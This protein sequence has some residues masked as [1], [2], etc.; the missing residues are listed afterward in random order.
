MPSSKYFAKVKMVNQ[1][2]VR[3][4]KM[5]TETAFT[6]KIF[7]EAMNHFVNTSGDPI[8][9]FPYE[10]EM[11]K[12]RINHFLLD[13]LNPPGSISAKFMQSYNL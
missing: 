13:I 11:L 8:E 6:H 7:T 9:V 5:M 4:L 1:E 12:H 10:P 2:W 3:P